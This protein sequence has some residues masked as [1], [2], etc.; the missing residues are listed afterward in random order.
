MRSPSRWIVAAV[1]CAATVVVVNAQE[2][3][4]PPAESN[5][6]NSGFRALQENKLLDSP[7]NRRQ[8]RD[9]R[10]LSIRTVTLAHEWLLFDVIGSIGKLH[11]VGPLHRVSSRGQR[12]LP[13]QAYS[14]LDWQV[15]VDGDVVFCIR[16]SRRW[17]DDTLITKDIEGESIGLAVTFVNH[18]RTIDTPLPEL[19][20]RTIR[21]LFDEAS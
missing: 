4:T 3:R 1:A 7:A 10:Q 13:T 19:K 11:Y 16:L 9:S 2:S 21:A 17:T 6:D 15:I 8:L 14:C 20:N 18:G 5:D 12:I